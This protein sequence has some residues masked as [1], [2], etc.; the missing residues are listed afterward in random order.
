MTD[1]LLIR[2][3]RYAISVSLG[4]AA[5]LP[6]ARLEFH[7]RFD[8]DVLPGQ[9]ATLMADAVAMSLGIF[10]RDLVLGVPE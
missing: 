5:L 1:L 6:G 9:A 4:A 8:G 10:P 3:G 7:P 2:P